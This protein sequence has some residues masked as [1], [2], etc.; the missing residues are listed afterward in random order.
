MDAGTAIRECGRNLVEQGLTWGNSGNIS[1]RIDSGAFMVTAGGTSLGTLQDKDI[2]RCGIEDESYS[3]DRYPSMET[4][5]H[6]EIY[7][8]CSNA[9]A[10][11]HSQPLYSTIAAC[12]SLI[13]RTDFLPEAMAYLDT[14]Q[15]VPYHHAGSRELAKATA[16]LAADSR[17][18]LLSNHGVV[19]W[20]DSLEEAL[21]ITQTLE[22]CCQLLIVSQ[23]S[24][25]DFNYL[26][27]DTT[28]DFRQHLGRI[29]R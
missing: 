17:V 29:G 23:G 16:T 8:A 18:L 5:L 12:S 2:I 28:A 20:G 21:I 7:R 22:F 26:G 9:R 27:E 15:R 10:V 13:I 3:G 14:V 25:L 19:C 11:I 1:A 24:G 6:R 4:G